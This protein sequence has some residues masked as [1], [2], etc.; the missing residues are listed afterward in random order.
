MNNYTPTIHIALITISAQIPAAQSLKAKRSVVK[1]LKEK[2]RAKFN[3]SFSEVGD[4][5]KWQQAVF[6]ATMVSN[7]QQHLERNVEHLSTFLDTF[8][9]IMVVDFHREF[10]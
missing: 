5:D 9:E 10:L 2:V 3:I 7:D 8:H 4:M 6:A 1:R